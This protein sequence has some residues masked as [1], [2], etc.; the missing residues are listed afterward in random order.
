ML[1]MLAAAVI[2]TVKTG[3]SAGAHP[4]ANATAVHGCLSLADA[5]DDMRSAIARV[6][7][8]MK[9]EC[10]CEGT[11]YVRSPCRNINMSM[12]GGGALVPGATMCGNRGEDGSADGTESKSGTAASRLA[13]EAAAPTKRVGRVRSRLPMTPDSEAWR[14]CSPERRRH[15]RDP[16]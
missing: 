12:C 13:C 5:R 15:G 11:V 8:H 9:R 10:S 14:G 7:T 16:L 6:P 1:G 4:A 3:H 2:H